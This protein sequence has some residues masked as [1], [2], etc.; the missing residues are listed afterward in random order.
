MIG[1]QGRGKGC[2]SENVSGRNSYSTLDTTTTSPTTYTPFHLDLDSTTRTG[3]LDNTLLTPP[4]NPS[5]PPNHGQ[6]ERRSQAQARAAAATTALRDL[7]SGSDCTVP[8]HPLHKAHERP[9]QKTAL[10]APHTITPLDRSRSRPQ[11]H[12]T[13]QCSSA[14]FTA[15]TVCARH[16][17]NGTQHTHRS[18][19]ELQ[20][21]PAKHPDR[22]H[23]ANGQQIAPLPQHAHVSLKHAYKVGEPWTFR[24]SARRHTFGTHL[25]KGTRGV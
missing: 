3:A 2:A 1:R 24:R 15:S 19:A 11:L 4:P 7:G 14:T 13:T 17:S 5:H 18:S 21:K 22:A 20:R 6:Q 16:S 9:Q 12:T 10:S 8:P 25:R 23:S